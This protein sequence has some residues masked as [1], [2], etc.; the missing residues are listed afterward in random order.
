MSLARINEERGRFCGG[1]GDDRGGTGNSSGAG[2]L[3]KVFLL[4]ELR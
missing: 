4:K 1:G 3:F 2:K